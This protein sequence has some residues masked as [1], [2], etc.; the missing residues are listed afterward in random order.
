MLGGRLAPLRL[1][2]VDSG[3]LRWPMLAIEVGDLTIRPPQMDDFAAWST[4]RAQS[5]DFLAPWE[6]LWPEDDLTRPSFRRRIRR[7]QSEIDSDE[8]YPFFVFRTAD[9][10]LL[11]G[12]TLGNVRRG[13]AQ[14]ASLGYWM[15]ENFAGQGIMGH[16]VAAVCRLG[17]NKLRLER[18][19]AACLEE[20]AAS[21]RLLEKAGFQRE[22]LARSYLNIAGR[23]R[24][25]LLFA[26]LSSDGRLLR[27]Q[28]QR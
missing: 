14:S 1:L 12:L 13:A 17:F 15:G 28:N 6:P 4:L 21:T 11:G 3:A 7:Y 24:D 16:S 18:I 9:M 10:M 26:L 23:R 8:A 20:N 19:E 27:D 25:H 5:R 2:G 22:G